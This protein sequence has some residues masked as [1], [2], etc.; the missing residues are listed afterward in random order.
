MYDY[1]TPREK[2]ANKEE[3]RMKKVM[4]KGQL[5]FGMPAPTKCQKLVCGSFAILAK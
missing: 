5:L 3:N 4:L 1:I 2:M